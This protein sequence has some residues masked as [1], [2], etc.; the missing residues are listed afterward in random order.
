MKE[1]F[2][3]P[4]CQLPLNF[5]KTAIKTFEHFKYLVY[6]KTNNPFFFQEEFYV[7]CTVPYCKTRRENNREN[8]LLFAVDIL[9]K[10]RI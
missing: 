1:R 5:M 4:V 6:L 3:C 2:F 10:A 9:Y 7:Y 8:G